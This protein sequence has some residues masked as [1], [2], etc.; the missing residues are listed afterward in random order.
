MNPPPVFRSV[1]LPALRL[2][3]GLLLLLAPAAAL[4]QAPAAA[5]AADTAG[6]GLAFT[7]Q[8]QVDQELTDNA[9]LTNSD[10][11]SD[12]RTRYTATLN[13][14][15]SGAQHTLALQAQAA[16]ESYAKLKQ[17][18]SNNFVLSASGEWLA[19]QQWKLPFAVSATRSHLRRGVL[20]DPSML[21][22]TEVRNRSAMLG[23]EW[24]D[25]SPWLAGLVLQKVTLDSE[26]VQR[27][28]GVP[29]T[30]DDQDRTQWDGTVKLGYQLAPPLQAY[31]KATRTLI[32]YLD[33]YDANLRQRDSHSNTFLLG[34]Q[35][36]VSPTLTGQL[37][38]GRATH[39]YLD[40]AFGRFGAP[41]A[42][43]GLSWQAS[44]RLAATLSLG[45]L[46]VETNLPGSPGAN[47]RSAQLGLA[48]QAL[49]ALATSLSYGRT[50]YDAQGQPTLHAVQ[51]VAQ[52]GAT[53]T[54][55][56]HASLKLNH[57]RTVIDATV[58]DFSYRDNT[59]A[60]SLV[61]S[62]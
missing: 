40:P 39:R 11:I 44:E 24:K 55:N 14:A 51:T 13:A 29:P 15:S 31:A 3:A 9:L 53:Y 36:A 1:C 38:A 33:P 62:Y 54:F 50:R 8:F 49:P 35:G 21:G 46:F 19:S 59:S 6:G 26:D 47:V 45:R 41:M 58:P 12:R 32:D 18:S 17:E 5:V 4:A 23:L 16:R 52:F 2:H 27:Q 37:E 42:T 48:W 43:L 20:D 7:P 34:L 61:F 25:T 30:R 56:R 60:L 57:V 10:A 22:L 28:A